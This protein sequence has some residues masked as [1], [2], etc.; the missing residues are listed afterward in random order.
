M[1]NYL[2][3]FNRRVLPVEKNS[4]Y[5]VRAVYR[6]LILNNGATTSFKAA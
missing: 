5:S 6:G 2:L 4:L 1:V 3:V